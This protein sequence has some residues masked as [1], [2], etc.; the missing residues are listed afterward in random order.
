MAV[1]FSIEENFLFG[2][3]DRFVW[4][5]DSCLFVWKKILLFSYCEKKSNDPFF[6]KKPESDDNIMTWF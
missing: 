4:L 5:I 2:N 6:Q 3:E 1:F